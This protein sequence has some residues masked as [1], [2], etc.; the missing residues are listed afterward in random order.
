MPISVNSESHR[1]QFD[2]LAIDNLNFGGFG[3][4]EK[5]EAGQTLLCLTLF[6]RENILEVLIILLGIL[7]VNAMF[8]TRTLLSGKIEALSMG[9]VVSELDLRRI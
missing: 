1:L 4:F 9:V 6:E 5:L 8:A 3:L 7:L 2:S